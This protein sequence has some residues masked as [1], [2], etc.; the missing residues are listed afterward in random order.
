MLDGHANIIKLFA[1]GM[2]PNGR[3][4]EQLILMEYCP[5]GHVVGIMN[6]RLNRRFVESEVLKVIVCVHRYVARWW[7]AV[8]IH[9]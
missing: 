6:R 5:G 8:L 7:T 3:F 1:S 2:R 4:T 9:S